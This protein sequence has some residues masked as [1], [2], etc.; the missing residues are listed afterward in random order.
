MPGRTK[1]DLLIR[2]SGPD[3]PGIMTASSKARRGRSGGVRAR[4]SHC[5]LAAFAKLNCLSRDAHFNFGRI[6]V[7]RIAH[8]QRR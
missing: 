4:A 1:V 3:L 8:R 2:L 6:D 5:A 7:Y